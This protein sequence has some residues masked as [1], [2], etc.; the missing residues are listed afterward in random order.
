MRMRKNNNDGRGVRFVDT[1]P[2]LFLME[3]RICNDKAHVG[4][5]TKN[6]LSAEVAKDTEVVAI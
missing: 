6:V 3:S 2:L 4:R 1:T 5:H